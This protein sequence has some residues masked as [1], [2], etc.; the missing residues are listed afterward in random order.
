M[1]PVFQPIGHMMYFATLDAANSPPLLCLGFRF[2]DDGGEAWTARFN[3]FKRREPAAV[4]GGARALSRAFDTI[5]MKPDGVRVVVVGAISSADVA[6]ADKA[7]V[8]RLGEVVAAR[9]KWEWRPDLLQK[10][11]HAS[12][13]GL[14]GGAA[15]RHAAVA[16]AYTSARVGG[17]AGKFLIVDDIATRGD[18][19]GEI[20]R[21]LLQANPGWTACGA[22]LAKSDRASFWADRGGISNGHVPDALRAAWDV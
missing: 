16:G 18:T 13:H 20:K 2:T 4:E 10:R 1:P 8:R 12:L 17:P 11:V 15:E 7:P 22:A 21:A 3:A 14:R 9:K 5:D 6:L 19:T